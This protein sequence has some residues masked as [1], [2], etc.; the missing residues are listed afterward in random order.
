[1]E[2]SI[3]HTYHIGGMGCNGCATTVKQKLS[4]VPAVIS[5]QVDLD[6]KQ[7][8]ITSSKLINLDSLQD[9]LHNSLY[10]ITELRV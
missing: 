8:Q 4:N 1:M 7:A 9:A 2:N 10:S 5:V 6:E 3:K